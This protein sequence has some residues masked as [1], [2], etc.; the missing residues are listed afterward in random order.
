MRGC[1]GFVF[2]VMALGLASATRR[3]RD[4]L[5]ECNPSERWTAVKH[6]DLTRAQGSLVRFVSFENSVD[7]AAVVLFLI[8]SSFFS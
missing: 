3:E 4:A 6:S 5:Q 8:R 7:H 2:V 1:G